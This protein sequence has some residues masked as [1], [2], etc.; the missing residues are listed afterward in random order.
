MDGA[1]NTVV[2]GS[3]D[4]TTGASLQCDIGGFVFPGAVGGG[5]G[6]MFLASFNASGTGL[7]A[8]KLG[9]IS[10]GAGVASIP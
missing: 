2:T 5:A 8:R 3:C 9:G 4:S 1:G 6:N 10:T 7:W